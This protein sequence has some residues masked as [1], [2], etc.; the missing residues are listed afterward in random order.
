MHRQCKKSPLQEILER[1][2][3]RLRSQSS[4]TIDEFT[5]FEKILDLLLFIEPEIEYST[6]ENNEKPQIRFGIP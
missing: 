1:E 2:I 5:L 3:N 6:G 4:L